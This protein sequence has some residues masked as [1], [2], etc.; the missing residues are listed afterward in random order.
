MAL[1]KT[2]RCGQCGYEA[3]DY[4]GR[5]F[6]GQHIVS[7]TCPDCKSIQPLVVGGVIGDSAPSFAGLAGR[8]CLRCGSDR[9]TAWNH[10]TC[11]KCGGEMKFTG[12]QQFWT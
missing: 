10:K 3:Y 7:V 2:Y 5:G 4:E 11:P 12:E 8:L 6:M 1:R 9:I